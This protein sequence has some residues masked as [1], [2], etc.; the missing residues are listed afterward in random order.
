MRKITKDAKRAFDL[1][2]PFNQGNTQVIVMRDIT[3]MYLFGNK[4]ARKFGNEIKISLAGWNTNTTRERLNAFAS[5][6]TKLGQAFINGKAVS[7][8]EWV[9][10]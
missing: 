1:N 4:I 10:L 6:S 7:D 8:N 3:E 9:T 2:I 5:V